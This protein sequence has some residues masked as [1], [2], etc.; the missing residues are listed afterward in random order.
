MCCDWKGSELSVL[1]NLVFILP[2]KAWPYLC[3]MRAQPGIPGIYPKHFP[4][5]LCL[6]TLSHEPGIP[7]AATENSEFHPLLLVYG[8]V[9]ITC[10][11]FFSFPISLQTPEKSP[12]P[13]AGS[14]LSKH[15]AERGW[16]SQGIPRGSHG[17]SQAKES[18]PSERGL[19]S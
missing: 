14:R 10:L 9:G 11:G 4:A 12:F 8:S 13:R 3:E 19:F 7:G 1:A 2:H 18:L 5:A 15:Q 16:N 17:S 6:S